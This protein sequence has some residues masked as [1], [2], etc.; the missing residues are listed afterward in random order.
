VKTALWMAA[1]LVPAGL[2]HFQPLPAA[3]VAYPQ[4]QPASYGSVA[5]PVG[6]DAI[7]AWAQAAAHYVPDT[8]GDHWEVP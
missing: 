6:I 8:S 3:Q 1:L 7:D 2:S 4:W 5:A